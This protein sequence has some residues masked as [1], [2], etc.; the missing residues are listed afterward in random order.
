MGFSNAAYIA[1]TASELAYG[2]LTM[3]KFLQHKGWVAGGSEWPFLKIS[4]III[5]YL[6]DLCVTTPISVENADQI[7][8]NALEFVLY[9]TLVYG[10]KIGRGKFKTW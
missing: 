7:H 6:D 4:E 5:I 2:Q 3:M 8:L 10:F 1:Q 9:A